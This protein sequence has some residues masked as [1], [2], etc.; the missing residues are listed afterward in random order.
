MSNWIEQEV[1]ERVRKQ[2]DR[3]KTDEERRRLADWF[4]QI[5]REKKKE[6]RETDK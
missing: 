1:Q 2:G 6:E 5:L 3:L 4:R